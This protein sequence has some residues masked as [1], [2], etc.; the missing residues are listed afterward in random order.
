MLR[1]STRQ[2]KA[3]TNRNRN[4]LSHSTSLS[5]LRQRFCS[6]VSDPD[7]NNETSSSPRETDS[8]LRSILNNSKN[9][10]KMAQATQVMAQ[11][12][13]LKRSN[14]ISEN[15]YK[16][17]DRF[18]RMMK[19]LESN[20]VNDTEPSVIVKGLKALAELGVSHDSYSVKNL[21]NG[22]MWNVRSCTIKD[23][24]MLLS[25]TMSRRHTESQDKLFNE[26]C[27]ALERRWVEIKDGRVFNSLFYYSEQFS[28]QFIARLEDRVSDV[29]DEISP[30]ELVLILNQMGKKKRRNVPLL[31]SLSFYIC[32]NKN[33][34]DVKQISDCLFS[35]NLLSFKEKNVVESLC[36][37][38][39]SKI[40]SV[41]SSAVLRSILTSLGQI[42]YLHVPLVDQIMIWYQT[43]LDSGTGLAPKD[44][45]S[46]VITLASLHYIPAQHT[47]LL[48]QV[49][50][51]LSQL[52]TSLSELVWLNAVWSLTV[53]GHASNDHLESVLNQNFQDVVL[54]PNN[55]NVG[56]TLKLLNINAAAKVLYPD[57]DGATMTVEDDALMKDVKF[58]PSATKLQFNQSVLE[59]VKT[60]C[61]EPKYCNLNV[62]TLLGFVTEADIVLN[63]KAQPLP[64]E[65]Y[66]NQFGQKE[67]T[68]PLPEGAKRVAVVS[69]S[70]QDCLLG[71]ELAGL[72]AFNI[73]LLQ[74]V[75][76]QV[77]LVKHTDWP[78]S[79]NQ[80]SRVSQIDQQFKS[81]VGFKE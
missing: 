11:I 7:N 71:G 54:L 77:V 59:S 22:L 62:N 29:V 40:S 57:Y 52:R 48:Q 76:Y 43:Q 63:D 2:V 72:T 5:I 30:G 21:E 38:L 16:N 25:F 81:V 23:L 17:D 70:F 42:K 13:H 75:G 64:V 6:Q 36:N 14:K 68:K 34:L 45:T 9:R 79:Q 20:I 1:F 55:R 41:E 74:A 67:P 50:L 37:E 58:S 32:K 39:V 53:L 31:K 51:E 10:N 8:D 18:G 80:V 66:S 4:E 26:V 12:A 24:M 69:A 19:L 61:P 35:F 47:K 60:L 49:A 56:A 3:F 46:L 78:S 33:M 44:L 15:D 73:K 27:R 28:P 65:D